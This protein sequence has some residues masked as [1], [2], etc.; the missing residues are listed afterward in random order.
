[1]S[2]YVP[3]VAYHPSER[4]LKTKGLRLTF[5]ISS[6]SITGTK[7][8]II[9]II[10]VLLREVLLNLVISLCRIV[11]IALSAVLRGWFFTDLS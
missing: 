4:V 3:P 7:L 2:S 1:M 11:C 8:K 10:P 6:L 5:L 9:L